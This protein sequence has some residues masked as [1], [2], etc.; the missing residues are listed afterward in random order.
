MAH[1][2]VTQMFTFSPSTCF[3]MCDVYCPEGWAE[4]TAYAYEGFQN[5]RREGPGV[6]NTNNWRV[7]RSIRKRFLR[8]TVSVPQNNL[9]ICWQY[10][11][12]FYVAV[13]FFCSCYSIS[14]EIKCFGSLKTARKKKFLP[15]KLFTYLFHFFFFNLKLCLNFFIE[16]EKRK[17]KQRKPKL[18]L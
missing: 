14:L 9:F 2:A 12:F 3:N 18:F 17:V 4:H 13:L 1:K 6:A 8:V 16:L 11:R 15:W 7:L 5:R 10:F